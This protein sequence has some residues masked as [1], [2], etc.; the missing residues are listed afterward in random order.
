MQRRP[1]PPAGQGPP[2]EPAPLPTHLARTPP[3]ALQI[4]A[5]QAADRRAHLSTCLDKLMV[6]V[7]R[8]LEAKNRD[9]FTQNLTIVR[10]DY[11]SKT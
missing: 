10:H 2:R 7:Q 5:S 8:N 11:R 6:D 1:W 3:P 9:K 4:I